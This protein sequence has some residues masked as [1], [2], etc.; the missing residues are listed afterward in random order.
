MTNY[1]DKDIEVLSDIEHVRL[2]TNVYLGSTVPTEFNIPIFHEND[3]ELK[4]FTF[5]PAVYRAICEVIDNSIDELI[6]CGVKNPT[7]TIDC[8]PLL[9]IYS[10]SDNGRGIPITK[11]STG[12]YT[13]EVVLSELRSGRNFKNDREIGVKGVNGV[14][15]SVVNFC[16]TYMNVII[17]R[18]GK[19]YKQQFTN[20]GSDISKPSIRKST[21]NKQGTTVEFQLDNQV[22][23]D[24]SLPQ[25]V[26]ESIAKETAFTNPGLTVKYNK[27]TFKYNKGFQDVIRKTT[28]TYYCFNADNIEYFFLPYPNNQ[29]NIFT[30]V[31]SSLLLDGGI[32]N[33]QFSNAFIQKTINSLTAKLSAKEQKI[34]SFNRS[35]VDKTFMAFGNIKTDA[36][37]YDAQAKTKLVG[38]SFRKTFDQLIND[39]WSDFSR[40]QKN[41]LNEILTQARAR[42]LNIENEKAAK[43]HEKKLKSAVK[44]IVNLID[45][46]SRTRKRCQLIICEGLS[47]AAAFTEV[48]D[49]AYTASLPLTGKVNNVR[50]MSP[51]QILKLPKYTELMTAIGLVPGRKADLSK[52]R[53]GRIIIATDSDVDG[54]HILTL[55]INF[56][57]WCWPELLNSKRPFLYR[58][59]APNVIASKGKQKRYFASLSEYEKQKAKYKSWHIDYIK[60]LGSM[61][62]DDYAEILSKD[63]YLLPIV[64]DGNLQE[65]LDM[66]FGSDVSQRVEWLSKK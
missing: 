12:K 62:R 55:L 21:A 29:T 40:K 52:L 50:G 57:Q 39:Q 9:G 16:S 35:D 42:Q 26:V 5:I 15:V 8:Q 17:H 48:R 63:K 61:Q 38:P 59:L 44:T 33:T 47:A 19:V 6:Q 53:Y 11:H 27:K 46:T 34:I 20:G 32:C 10:I 36:P 43:L 25:D 13:P 41:W 18:D 37:Q 45:A 30:W 31:N 60:G 1:T 24:V 49:P 3:F 7:I 58:L 56:F 23:S 66:L 22:F 64:D 28:K 14:G 54:G 51:A 4:T 65:T 2:R